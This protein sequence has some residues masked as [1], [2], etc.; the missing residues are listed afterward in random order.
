MAKLVSKT[1]GEALFQLAIEQNKLDAFMEELTGIQKILKENPDFNALMNHPKIKKDEKKKIMRTVFDTRVDR[2]IVGLFDLVITKDRYQE[3][4]EI[5]VY[6]IEKA[7]LEKRIGTVTIVSAV[8]IKE[9]QK[10][11]ILDKL[12]KTTNFETMETKYTVDSNL[13]GGLVIRIGDRVVDSSIK[14]K[15]E[16]MQKQL[17][18]IQL[19]K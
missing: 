6:F 13:I 17:L 1:Y 2:E 19:T 14:T 18:K 15:L 4:D 11:K 9:E 3:M 8:E 12:L 5:L 10:Q 16:N 7:K